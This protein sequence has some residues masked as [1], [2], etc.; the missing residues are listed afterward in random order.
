MADE[1][2]RVVLAAV[3]KLEQS[4]RVVQQRGE[5]VDN[6]YCGLT[7]ASLMEVIKPGAASSSSSSSSGGKTGGSAAAAKAD[8]CRHFDWLLD[9]LLARRTELLL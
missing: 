5:Q 6:T 3:V 4:M 1:A 9:Q 8:I 2:R 7:G